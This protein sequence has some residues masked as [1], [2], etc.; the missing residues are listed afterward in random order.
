[1]YE[2]GTFLAYIIRRAII[3]SPTQWRNLFLYPMFRTL[4]ISKST[5]YRMRVRFTLKQ[6]DTV[7]LRTY[8]T[9]PLALMTTSFTVQLPLFLSM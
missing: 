4:V 1:M 5:P 3:L 7:R 8:K 2:L 9:A 6:K